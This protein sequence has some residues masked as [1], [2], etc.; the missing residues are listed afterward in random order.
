MTSSDVWT[1]EQA[2]RY[3][4]EDGMFSPEVLAPTVD[5]LVAMA[6]GGRVL[7]LAIGTGRVAVPLRARGVSVAGIELSAAMV[8]N[9]CTQ[10]EQVECFRNAARHLSPGGRFVVEVGVPSLRRLPP[11]Q[12]AVPFDVSDKHLGF[13]TYDLVSQQASSHHLTRQADGTYRRGT[14]NYRYVWP[15]ELDLMAQLA[16]MQLERRTQ[17]WVATPFTSQSEGHV[18]VWRLTP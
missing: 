3:D 1:V 9:L 17:D 10:Q 18:S 13:D 2:K 11:G 8:G 5:A 15:S 6:D 12:V 16:G 7:E 4:S 14:H